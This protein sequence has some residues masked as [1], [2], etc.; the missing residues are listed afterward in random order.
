M[1][2]SP[3][4]VDF[5]WLPAWHVR[6]FPKLSKFTGGTVEFVMVIMVHQLIS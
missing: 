4:A 2:K 1:P 6:I 5:N 3:S